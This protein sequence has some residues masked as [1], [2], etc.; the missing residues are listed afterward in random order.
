MCVIPAL[1]PRKAVSLQGLLESSLGKD[2]TA[3]VSEVTGKI[4]IHKASQERQIDESTI[5][6][7]E[8]KLASK[9]TKIEIVGK[10]HIS[11]KSEKKKKTQ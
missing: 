8:I 9:E 3:S 7:K 10:K 1:Y 11:K 4:R 5:S 2:F 6:K